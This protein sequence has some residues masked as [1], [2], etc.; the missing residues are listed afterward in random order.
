MDRKEHWERVYNSKKLTE[1]SWYQPTPSTSLDFIQELGITKDAAIIDVGGGDSFLADHLL[2]RGFTNITVLDI[3]EAAIA[4]A[5]KRLGG[6]A[7]L[8]NWVVS[9]IME[10][11]PDRH[12]DCWHDRAA[13]HFLTSDEE[14]SKYLAIANLSL[15]DSGKIIIGT[16]SETGPEKCSGLA[17]KQYSEEGLGSLIKKWF[18]KIKCIHTHHLTPFNSIQDFLFCS[19]KK[20]QP[21]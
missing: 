13:F 4:R 9:D 7:G 8:V 10:Y 21:S 18:D 2:E 12:F 20:H 5:Q 14:I 1:V 15:A 11:Q 6:K 19:F 16:F 3:S 17:I